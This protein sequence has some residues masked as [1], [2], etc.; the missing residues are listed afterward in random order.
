MDPMQN[1]LCRVCG[2]PAAGFHFGAFTCEGCKSFFGRT[3]N[4]QSVIGECKNHYRCVVDKKNR[5]SCKAC[6]LRKCL[7]VGMSKSGSRY[8]RRSNWFKIHCLMQQS[9][10][11]GSDPPS[12]VAAQAPWPSRKDDSSSDARDSSFGSSSRSPSPLNSSLERCG[13][14][15]TDSVS[16]PRQA[17]EMSS[18]SMYSPP[19]P[20]YSLSP[21]LT[22]P[23]LLSLVAGQTAFTAPK[24]HLELLTEHRQLLA[25]FGAARAL[26]TAG[27]ETP[28]LLAHSGDAPMDL[29][30][31]LTA[32]T[33]LP[34]TTNILPLPA[35]PVSSAPDD[36]GIEED[37]V[38]K[39]DSN[40][41]ILT[42]SNFEERR[43]ALDLTVSS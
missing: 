7:M 41:N 25:K 12:Q 34:S 6:R 9:P 1:Q 10:S 32:S 3:C 39:S 42:S 23:L 40:S 22:H 28:G 33:Y 17:A 29:S 37:I 43:D 24:S 20:F 19:F 31:K 35:S 36:E 11:S 30:I 15:K 21:L 18:P 5:T 38:E 26:A 4:N 14:E 27:Q 8:G 13:K 16:P 2:E